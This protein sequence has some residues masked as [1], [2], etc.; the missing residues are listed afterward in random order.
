MTNAA[1]IYNPVAGGSPARRER[2]ARE[3]ARELQ[4]AG[5]AARLLPTSAPGTAGE[6]ARGAVRE[7]TEL[8]LVCGGD[9]TLNEVINGLAPGKV[10][11]AVLPGGTANVF[12]R[13]LGINLNPVRAARQLSRWTPRRVA[14]GRAAWSNGG[15]AQQRFFLS[16]AGVGFD[17]YIIHNLSRSF[18]NAL[19]VV[20]YGCE[21]LRQVFRYS[22]PEFSCRFEEREFR[23]TFAVL[24]RTERYAAWLRIAPGASVFGDRFT[25]CLFKSRRR[26]RYFLYAAAVVTSTHTRLRDVETMQTRRIEFAG[27]S[28]APVYFELDGEWVGRLPAT[29][30]IVPNALTVLVP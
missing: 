19:G 29:F 28:G 30:E 14:L 22:F 27:D 4:A 13:E 9:G 20:A 12:A 17:A 11:L 7:G 16:L 18:A 25:L 2:Q 26:A 23:G 10:P 3:A 1:L 5:V 21:G 24:H 15:G 8:V 6:L